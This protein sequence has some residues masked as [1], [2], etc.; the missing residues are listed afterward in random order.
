MATQ[1]SA[2][3]LT[4]DTEVREGGGPDSAATAFGAG[5]VGHQAAV[6]L[7]QEHATATV[8]FISPTA[9]AGT[10]T[11]DITFAGAP[12]SNNTVDCRV[13]G[14]TF[15]VT[16]LVGE[17]A[18]DLKTKVINAIVQRTNSLAA[19][20]SSGGAGI[21]QIDSKVDGNI[22]NDIIVSFTL[23]DGTTGTETVNATTTVTTNLATGSSDPDFTTAL[24]NIEGREYHYIL[25]CLS[26][27]D[28][29]NVASSNNIDKTVTHIDSLNTG[30]NAKLQQFIVGYTGTL[31]LANASTVHANSANNKEYG[32]FLLCI[33]GE[34][35]PGA[36][37]GR[38]CGG[39]L[40]AVSVDPAANRIGEL[41]DGYTGAFDKIADKPTAAESESAL[42]NGVSLVSYSAQD[43]ELL[44]RAVTTHSQDTGGGSD[45]RLLDVQNVDAAYIVSRDIRDNLPLQFPQAKIVADVAEGDDP[46]PQ[47]VVQPRD[48]KAW[49]IS[50]LR[51]WQNEAVVQQEALDDAI[52]NGTII[53]QVNASDA[54][55]VDI[56]MPFEIVQPLA[57]FGVTAQRVPS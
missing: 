44:V 51:F 9:G 5:T 6:L 42:G 17:S 28:A 39:R 12:T 55:Q 21:V 7:Y 11:A 43:S 52:E 10:A 3:D 1:S 36:L 37:G 8:D 19:T 40:A 49:I 25:L 31:A 50:R 13:H 29:A 2:G 34:G 30:L 41:L 16:W 27:T 54:T 35:L 32:E 48:I 26:N 56:V 23:R 33:S 47:G 45:T 18:D 53:V 20:A 15:E 46:P 38:E 14:V 57:K 4:D 22:G 24:S